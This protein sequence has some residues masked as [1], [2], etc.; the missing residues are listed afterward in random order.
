M[1]TDQSHTQK[2]QFQFDVG[3]M[4][5]RVSHAIRNPLGIIRSTAELL[6]HMTA[7]DATQKKLTDVIIDASDRLDNIVTTFQNFAR[8]L[9]PEIQPC[10]LEEVLEKTISIFRGAMEE[11]YIDLHYELKDMKLP[12]G[13]DPHQLH[14]A[15]SH[16]LLNA[17]QAMTK[18]GTLTIQAKDQ[19]AS[20]LI[21]IRDS[22]EG[23]QNDHLSQ[24]FEPFFSTREKGM[25]LGLTV[26]KNI[27]ADHKGSVW[28]D[29]KRGGGARVVVQLPKD[30]SGDKHG[31]D[32]HCR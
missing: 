26:A 31:N 21:E 1:T 11:K 2:K 10:N 6:G 12:L 8:P 7:A 16:I 20:Y 4:V 14:Q 24:V 28:I 29:S 15:F 32:T 13:G 19:N 25:G 17:L 22:G 5:S 27:V 9:P 23:I 30:I 3:Q 18:G